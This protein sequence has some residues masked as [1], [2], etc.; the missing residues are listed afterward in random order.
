VPSPS[1]EG[2]LD[3]FLRSVRPP[4]MRHH[5]PVPILEADKLHRALDRHA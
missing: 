4:Q 2:G 5:P 3:G 1:E